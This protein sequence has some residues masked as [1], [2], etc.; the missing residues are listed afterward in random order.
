MA[1]PVANIVVAT[2]TMTGFIGRFNT[3]AA[4]LSNSV[5]TT[6]ANSSGDV[7]TGNAQFTGVL[8]GNV[9]CVASHV[10]GGTMAAGANLSI[11]SNLVSQQAISGNTLYANNLAN[12]GSAVVRNGFT[13]NG[14]I[15][16]NGNTTITGN[17][18]ISNALTT[19]TFTATALSGNVII[20]ANNSRLESV[21]V[22]SLGANVTAPNTVYQFPRATFKTAKIAMEIKNGTSLHRSEIVVAHN[23]TVINH[24]AYATVT[25]PAN[26]SL[27]QVSFV[28]NGTN[29]AMQ[30][31][32]TTAA[33][34]VKVVADLFID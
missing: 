15:A 34:R 22:A 19:N 27:G 17:L 23:N 3:V 28:Y 32:Q 8:A 25:A 33:S 30:V 1:R 2:D 21:T 29:V 18:T 13:A 16:L 14:V 4:L 10:R 9:F 6:A 31:L 12:V 7:N 20:V 5:V 24:T 26:N 11:T